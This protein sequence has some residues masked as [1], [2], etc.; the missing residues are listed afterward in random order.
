MAY[1]ASLYRK[2]KRILEARRDKAYN[3]AQERSEE[4]RKLCPEVDS[5]QKQLLGVGIEISQLFIFKG[6][7]DEK[8]PS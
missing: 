4:I 5:I 7:T 2:A 1:S 3:E 6:N 8:L